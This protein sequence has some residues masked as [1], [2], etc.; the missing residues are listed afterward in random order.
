MNNS[1]PSAPQ[2][3]AFDLATRNL[4][5]LVGFDGS[6][7]SIQ[8]LHFGALE[9][10]RSGRVLTVVTVVSVPVEIYTT[11]HALPEISEAHAARDAAKHVL[12]DARNYLQDYPGRVT[13]R[14][15]QG[16]VTAV[17][18]ELSTVAQLIVVGARGRGGFLGR[19][20]GSVSSSLPA[21]AQCPVIVVP[22]QYSANAEEGRARFVPQPDTRPVVVGI[23]GSEH[24][25]VAALH[26]ARAAQD[27]GATLRLLMALPPLKGWMDWYP[28]LDAPEQEI[29]DRR[30]SQ[31]ENSLQAEA[32]WVSRHFPAVTV[33]A[34]VEPG[35]PVAQLDKSTHEAQLTV[36]GTR[37]HG[38]FAGALLGSV[39]RGVLL[40]AVGPVMVVPKLQDERLSDQPEP[41][42]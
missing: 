23:D 14:T 12:N 20:L 32:E 27:R 29:V 4:G 11:L 13:F 16:D 30:Q 35:D 7:Q 15:E 3:V 2:P 10:Q 18:L 17:M 24:S 22:Q 34:A 33:T 31:L 40:R 39:S 6:P 28:E 26:A 9:A 36:V 21:H 1:T 42:R 19:I 41:I 25:R 5:V 8:A 37:G 38:E